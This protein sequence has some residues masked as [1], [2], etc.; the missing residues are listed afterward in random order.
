MMSSLS[1]EN[2]IFFWPAVTGRM[3]PAYPIRDGD[4]SQLR[5]SRGSLLPVCQFV[6][7]PAL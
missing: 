1:R 7:T 5:V 2:F 3:D 6:F 4:E